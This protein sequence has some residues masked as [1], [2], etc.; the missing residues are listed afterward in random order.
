MEGENNYTTFP[1]EYEN[2]KNLQNWNP[3]VR[4]CQANMYFTLSLCLVQKVTPCST[5]GCCVVW[6]NKDQGH[7]PTDLV[8]AMDHLNRLPELQ[9]DSQGN[10]RLREN[11]RLSFTLLWKAVPADTAPGLWAIAFASSGSHMGFLPCLHPHLG[12]VALVS[13][14]CALPRW[15]QKRNHFQTAR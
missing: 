5:V 6:S 10:C 7:G 4:G 14:H 2:K 3:C 11:M 13:S 9:S 12:V 15:A 8:L 1:L